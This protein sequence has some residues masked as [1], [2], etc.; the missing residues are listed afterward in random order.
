MKVLNANELAIVAGGSSVGLG[1]AADLCLLGLAVLGAKNLTG[2]ALEYASDPEHP[3]KSTTEM[4]IATG[5]I[6]VGTVA[7]LIAATAY[8]M[9]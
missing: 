8:A 3:T 6:G 2:L 7:G 9:C 4:N 5:I 1:I